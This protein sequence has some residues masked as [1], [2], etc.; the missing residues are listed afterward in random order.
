M[1]ETLTYC[2][3][4]VPRNKTAQELD[5]QIMNEYDEWM[6]TIEFRIG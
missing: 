3:Y 5:C 2:I 6:P 4:D 1:A